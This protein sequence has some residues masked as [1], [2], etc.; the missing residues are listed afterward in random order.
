[1]HLPTSILLVAATLLPSALAQV[2]FTK[3]DTDKKLNLSSPEITI[4]WTVDNDRNEA[5]TPLVD[6]WFLAAGFGYEL[7]KDFPSQAGSSSLVWNPKDVVDALMSTNH[8]LP[9]GK[10]FQFELRFHDRNSSRGSGVLSEKYAVEGY[11]FMNSARGRVGVEMG[12]VVVAGL[13]GAGVWLL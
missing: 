9:G 5:R 8:S 7:K 12:A 11:R 6:I 1:M 13:V 4:A 3:P 10:E 2:R